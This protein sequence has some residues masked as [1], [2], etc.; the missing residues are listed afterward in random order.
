[1]KI[2]E[3]SIIRLIVPIFMLFTII[4]ITNNI[5][6]AVISVSTISCTCIIIFNFINLYQILKKNSFNIKVFFVEINWKYYGISTFLTCIV[7]VFLLPNDMI[8]ASSIL[9]LCV[10]VVLLIFDLIRTIFKL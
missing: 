4:S 10:L 3:K 1:M 2:K 5:K 7:Y 6:I 9:I 8:I